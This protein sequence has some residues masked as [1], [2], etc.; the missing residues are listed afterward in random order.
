MDLRR[1]G[2]IFRAFMKEEEHLKIAIRPLVEVR[3]IK[4]IENEY[5]PVKVES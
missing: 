1:K 5:M 3:M 2:E 4:L